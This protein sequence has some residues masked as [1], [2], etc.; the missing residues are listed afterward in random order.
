MSLNHGGAAPSTA[1]LE[2]GKPSPRCRDRAARWQQQVYHAADR[3]MT[4]YPD[5]QAE[6]SAMLDAEI[7]AG[8]DFTR[9]RRGS[10]F[11]TP[12]KVNVDRNYLARI[13]FVAD[14]IERKTYKNRAK[15]KH[16]GELGRN[17]MA[18]LRVLLFV[19]KKSGGC[20]YPSY[21]T[22]AHLARMSRRAVIAAMGVLKLMGFVTV[23][24]RAKV[25]DTPFG[26][27]VV[28]DS[29]CYA[30]HMPEGLGALAWAI[31]R[32]A[33]ECSK[34]PAR[35]VLNKKEEATGEKVQVRDRG[36]PL[37]GIVGGFPA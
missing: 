36:P 35:S 10:E 37:S 9:Y 31:F 20:L 1:D 18:L 27:K 23:Y 33:S 12:P 29:N 21:E 26:R 32:P 7:E 34:F 16:G 19:V 25:I 8:P 22:L 11:R 15:G 3:L 24:R 13:M 6:I 14:T 30:Y 2:P 4:A 5:K 17:A 28:Q